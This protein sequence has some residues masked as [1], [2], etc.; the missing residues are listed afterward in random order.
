MNSTSIKKTS[1]ALFLILSFS[2]NV[3]AEELFAT[4]QG[5]QQGVTIRDTNTLKQKVYRSKNFYPS[6]IALDTNKS[7][8][9]PSKNHLQ[10]YDSN[11]TLIIEKNLFDQSTT[12][13][14]VAL[15]DGKVY[16]A[17]AGSNK[18]FIIYDA[19]TLK[20]ISS[21]TIDIDVSGIAVDSSLNV[22][23]SAANNIFKY[24]P[25]CT[26]LVEMIFPDPAIN[27]TGVTIFEDKNQ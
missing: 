23:L 2:I 3:N 15:K 14:S 20:K 7:Y 12:F 21:C 27:Y 13:T 26:L 5:S 16:A 10:K 22:Y 19:L 11:G 6:D 8:Y 1:M 18:G 9:L 4:Y 17:Y 24:S 25:T